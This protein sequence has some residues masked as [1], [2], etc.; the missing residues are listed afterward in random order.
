MSWLDD[1]D[2][3]HLPKSQWEQIVAHCTRKLAGNFLPGESRVK[4]AYG[5]LAG[6]ESEHGLL[7]CRVLPVKKNA[8]DNE[9]LKSYMD[10]VMAEYALPST[11]P[12]SQRGWITDPEELMQCYDL[13]DRENLLILGTY[14][15]HI[16]PWKGDPVR[17]T[18]TK[19]DTILAK[20]SNLY[21]FII[22]MVE[23]ERPSI[24]AFFEGVTEGQTLISIEG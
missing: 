21:S 15:M 9:P 13:C 14:H 4:R 22:S 5:I 8:R 24:K 6:V 2:K 19:L 10:K 23:V 3:I 12:L 11:T 20:D 7:V 1:I 17:D 16:V 18:P